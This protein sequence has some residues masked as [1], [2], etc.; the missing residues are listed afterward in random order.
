MLLVRLFDES[1]AFLPAAG[2]E[3]FRA[4]LGL[5][6]AQAGTV[7]ALI[8]PGALIGTVFAAAADRYSRRVIAAGGAF[9]FAACL[10][11]FAAGGSFLALAVASLA[12]GVASTA[13]VD[14]AEVALVD[15]AGDDLRRFLARGNLLATVGDV[16]GPALVTLTAVLGFSWRASFW[17]GSILIGLYGLALA[18]SPLP[19]PRRE[20]V[21][22]GRGSVRS[23]A[24]I[25]RDVVRDRRVWVVG[26]MVAVMLL[27]S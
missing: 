22:D 5:T 13:M 24:R 20:A 11:A 25:L 8:A 2:L 18:A 4:D 7:L 27:P 9:G 10:A 19:G 21:E 12:M 17:A 3:S 15:M 23:T 1:A 6:Y 16:A 14:A 26:V